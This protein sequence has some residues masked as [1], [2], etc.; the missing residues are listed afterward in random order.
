MAHARAHD[1]GSLSLADMTLTAQDLDVEL[2][3]LRSGR[4]HRCG[5]VEQ[6]DE[7][8]DSMLVKNPGLCAGKC[9]AKWGLFRREQSEKYPWTSEENL[10]DVLSSRTM[11]SCEGSPWE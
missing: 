11:I 9:E 8:I 1:R 7:I 6:M 5:S 3:S 10:D 4:L 2:P